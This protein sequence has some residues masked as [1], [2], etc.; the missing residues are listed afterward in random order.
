MAKQSTQELF[1]ESS[2]GGVGAVTAIGFVISLILA[3]GGLILMSYGFNPAMGATFEM[4]T[5]VAGLVATFLGFALPFTIL[6]A[7]GR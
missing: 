5:F 4:W 6:P 7:I 2:Q 1:E 3:F